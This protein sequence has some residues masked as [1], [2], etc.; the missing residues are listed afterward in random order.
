MMRLHANQAAHW[1]DAAL[2]A[3]DKAIPGEATHDEAAAKGR[4]LD[5]SA[6]PKDAPQTR[7]CVRSGTASNK[8]ALDEAA[9]NEA[10]ANEGQR[11]CPG[12]EAAR[13]GATALGGEAAA[14]EAAGDEAARGDSAP[15][16]A[17]SWDE[18]CCWGGAA[19]QGCKAAADEATPW[20]GAYPNEAAPRPSSD[21]AAAQAAQ[22]LEEAPLPGYGEATADES[23]PLYEADPDEAAP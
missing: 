3:T 15:E 14:E 12:S 19:P 6:P 8:A 18:C 11:R 22:Q 4:T 13:G 21:R 16:G 2:A 20:D 10:A 5:E 7:D 9:H 17:T 1:N 23:T